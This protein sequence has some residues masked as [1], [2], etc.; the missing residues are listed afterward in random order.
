MWERSI[1]SGCVPISRLAL[2]R[3]LSANAKCGWNRCLQKPKIGTVCAASACGSSGGSTVKHSYEQRDKISSACAKI[4]DEDGV[5]AQK[6]PFLPS[7][8]MLVRGRVVIV[9]DM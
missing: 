9:W 1:S 7:F 6:K 4:V 3:K 5:H 2:T 8:W